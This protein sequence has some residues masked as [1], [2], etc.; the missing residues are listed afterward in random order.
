MKYFFIF[1]VESIGLHGEGFAVAGGVYLRNGAIQSGFCF[2]CDPDEALGSDED[3]L[4]VKQNVPVMEI[5]HR[6]PLGAR[7]AF[8]KKW[9]EAKARYPGI[10]MMAECLWPVEARFVAACVE[11]SPSRNWEGPYPFHEIASFMAAAGMD[12]METYARRPSEMPPHNPFADSRLSARLLVEALDRLQERPV[13]EQLPACP[14]CHS[15]ERVIVS[16][17]ESAERGPFF[18]PCNEPGVNASGHFTP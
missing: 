17:P 4:W 8:W 6:G 15:N 2:C 14:C 11:D 5:T 12:P 3:R 1:D 18:C 7:D 9:E 10:V 13:P 16:P